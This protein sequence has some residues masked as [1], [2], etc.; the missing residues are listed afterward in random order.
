MILLAGLGN[1]GR[2]YSENRHNFGFMAVDEIVRRHNFTPERNRFQGLVREGQIDGHKVLVLK[3]AT[4]MNESGR[5]ISEAMRFYK[6]S[7]DDVVVLHDELDLPV[8]KVRVKKGGGH[9]GNNGVRSIIA[10]IGKEFRRVRMGIDHPGDKNLVSGY[11]LKDF[12]KSD[13]LMVEKVI[14]GVVSNV[15]LLI[16]GEDQKFMTKV[17]LD[18]QPPKKKT[19]EKTD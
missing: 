9:G 15:A 10:A 4:Y 12:P 17:A 13:R 2:G 19:T 5:A 16:A 1:P 6:I 11:V 18:L 14:D 8:G 3:P 7:L